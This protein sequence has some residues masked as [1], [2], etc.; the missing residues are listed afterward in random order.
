MKRPRLFVITTLLLIISGSLILNY[1]RKTMDNQ[2]L[3]RLDE[4]MLIS[5]S[6]GESY[7]MLPTNTVLHF[8]RGFA[9]GHQLYTVQVFS[10]GK[11]PATQIAVN[12][13]VESTWIYPIDAEDI[14][15][16][17]SQYPLSK[18]DLIRILKARKM[19]RDDLAQI[20][21]EWKDD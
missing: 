19:T 14:P 4:P 2:A 6:K 12:A 7:Y 5:S 16:I 3:Y 20:V 15:K 13:P 11:L 10:K 8:Q 1:W 18:D 9:E 17:L 21:R